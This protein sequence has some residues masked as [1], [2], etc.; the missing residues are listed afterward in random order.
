MVFSPREVGCLVTP[1]DE[2]NPGSDG[3][4]PG[5]ALGITNSSEIEMKAG[6]EG[7][8]L[9]SRSDRVERGVVTPEA[10]PVDHQLGVR[11]EVPVEPGGEAR[12]VVAG[13]RGHGRL[14]QVEMVVAERNLERAETAVAKLL[15][16]AD[17]VDIA[18]LERPRLAGEHVSGVTI[19]AGE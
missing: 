18:A 11:I 7:V 12:G 13:A 2:P 3:E 4:R 16:R 14:R 9:G 5:K 8:A 15:E 17:A 1:S 19:I 10:D 6:G